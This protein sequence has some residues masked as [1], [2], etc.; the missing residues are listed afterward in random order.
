VS[1]WNLE[2]VPSTLAIHAA[3][4]V[5]QDPR[6]SAAAGDWIHCD[7][8]GARA[9]IFFARPT[10][11]EEVQSAASAPAGA[12]DER[13]DDDVDVPSHL[14]RTI[15]AKAIGIMSREELAAHL[16]RDGGVNPAPGRVGRRRYWATPIVFPRGA[17]FCSLRSRAILEPPPVRYKANTPAHPENRDAR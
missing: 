7:E 16:G 12:V 17:T 8:C 10:S 3:W 15:A 2:E 9:A 6:G 13:V 4:S 5:L 14:Y 1:Y 11:D